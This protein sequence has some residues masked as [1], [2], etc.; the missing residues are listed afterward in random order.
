MIKLRT[1][2]RRKEQLPADDIPKTTDSLNCDLPSTTDIP[3]D[4]NQE[5]EN[6]TL[7]MQTDACPIP[8]SLGVKQDAASG[9]TSPDKS[10]SVP[11]R[12]RV[13]I[14]EDSKCIQA[15]SETDGT[16]ISQARSVC[17]SVLERCIQERPRSF[18]FRFVSY[19]FRLFLFFLSF[20]W[21]LFP[22]FRCPRLFRPFKRN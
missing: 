17:S 3:P 21:C 12:R 13:R 6:A 9:S 18:L 19:I 20:A 1:Q 16:L 2:K 11:Q 7:S 10:T 8:Q 5:K 14:V 15:V 4:T 22:A